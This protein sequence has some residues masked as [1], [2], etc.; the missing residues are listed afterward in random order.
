LQTRSIGKDCGLAIRGTGPRPLVNA[1]F[2]ALC[3]DVCRSRRDGFRDKALD[4]LAALL[5]DLYDGAVPRPSVRLADLL[6]RLQAALADRYA[7]QRE[8]GR[9]GM[10]TVYLAQDL[11]HDRPVALKVLRPDLAAVLGGKRFLNEIRITAKLDH[12]HILTLID[13]GESDGFLWY[14]LPYVRGESLRDRLTRDKQLG[15]EEAL[16]ITTQIAG[17][18]EYAHQHGVIHRDIKPENIL[19]HEG[20]AMLADFGI[21]LAAREAGGGRLTESGISLGTPQYMSPEQA[22]GE[23]QPDARSDVYSLGAVLYEMLAGEPPVTGTTAQ[24][25]IAKLLTERPTRLRVIRDGVPEGVDAAVAR[26]LAKTPADRFASAGQFAQALAQDNAITPRARPWRKR[27]GVV[28]ALVAVGILLK[29]TAVLV[30]GGRGAASDPNRVL[31]LTFTDESGP[32]RSPALGR[33]AQDYIIQ[34]LTAAG[35]AN[36]IDPLTAVAVSRNVSAAG[37]V[38]EPGDFRMLATEAAAGTVIS[39]SYYTQG[40][41]IFV[42]TRISDTRNSRLLGT[43]GPIGG[44]IAEASELVGRVGNAVVGALAPLLD[45]KLGA[46]DPGAAPASLAAYEAYI[47]GLQAYLPDHFDTAASFFERAIAIDPT[48]TRARL[49]AAQSHML[50]GWRGTQSEFVKAESLLAP[51]V[52]S[53]EQLSRYERCRL[54]FVMAMGPRVNFVA[55]YAAARCMVQA[56]PGSDDARREVALNALRINRPAESKQLLEQLDR[57]HGLLKQWDNYWF[58]LSHAYHMLGDYTGELE[59]AR[60]GLQR[61]P[62]DGNLK[63]V[64]ARALAAL[65]RIDDVKA[66][67]G[68]MRSQN[69]E[70][71]GRVSLE[72]ALELRAHG[73]RD[74][75]REI[76]DEPIAWYLS[77]RHAVYRSRAVLA[78]M[79]YVAERWGDAQ[80]LYQQLAKEH[81]DPDTLWHLTQLGCLAARRGDR[82]TALSINEQLRTPLSAFRESEQTYERAKI[83]ALLGDREQAVRLLYQSYEE[84]S[85]FGI[86]GHG[87]I[88]FESLH[89]YPPFQELIRPK[90]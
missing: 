75:Y 33:M 80:R 10:A 64:E 73:H 63:W 65:G 15:I 38:T 57:Q 85:N 42:L 26:A 45:K 90:G 43:V 29:E 69:P 22:T 78:D 5:C 9:G 46:W 41:S 30:H 87:E 37:I 51:L 14:V 12:P 72:V 6:A 4:P 81:P 19:F 47:D 21:A 88:D 7:I 25:M 16:A 84:G 74:A 89:D 48:F 8:L 2:Q 1:P 36:V 40:D 35:F 61:L 39:G 32:E 53:R 76:L 67:L 79:L 58:Y 44:R 20:E 28:L 66:L 18:L 68:A 56:A 62:G 50:M 17:A 77:Q 23:R 83:A 31:V 55:M 13:S 54:D 70:G 52:R 59:V 86:F 27:A 82:Q 71:L 34:V 11:K 3:R 49:W 24:A 60:Q